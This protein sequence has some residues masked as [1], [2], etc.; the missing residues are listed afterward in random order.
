MESPEF[1][2]KKMFSEEE[3]V[4]QYPSLPL[5]LVEPGN[6]LMAVSQLCDSKQSHLQGFRRAESLWR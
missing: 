4:S 5:Q 1:V 6:G 3:L 2:D